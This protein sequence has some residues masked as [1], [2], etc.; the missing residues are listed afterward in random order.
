[1]RNI[2]LLAPYP[3]KEMLKDGMIQ[4][5]KI[6][7]DMLLKYDRVYL[8][9]SFSNPAYKCI[10]HT[11]N[12]KEFL[13][14]PILSIFFIIKELVKAKI[15]YAHS[16][17]LFK[18]MPYYFWFLKRKKTELILDAHGIVPEEM[19]MY[20]KQKRAKYLNYIESRV[21][22]DL[23][24]CICVSNEMILHYKRKY[25]SSNAS[26]HLFNTSK[27]LEKP[28]ADE[29]EMLAKDL[30][31][32]EN[33]CVILYSGNTQLWQN[34][35]LMLDYIV[36]LNDSGY[37]FIFL[38]GN[39]NEM[40]KIIETAGLG[41][42]NIIIRSVHHNEI[43]KYYELAHYGFILRDDIPINKV[44]NPTK[45]LEYLQF[46]LTPIVL[47]QYIGDYYSMGYEY[48][49]VRTLSS[50]TLSKKKSSKNINISYALNEENKKFEIKTL[51]S[52]I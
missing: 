32:I 28:S 8:N 33:D 5:I 31:I 43:N 50:A 38:T 14:N 15:I 23:K 37:K 25:S 34:V 45:M 13:L 26:Y 18:F 17:H 30:N 48:I 2:V 51:I 52:Q 39:V 29:V 22:R 11:E 40:Q 10:K 24:H 1:M 21:F 9:I 44:S 20:G 4:R 41:S 12:S 16:I 6:I 7:D 35:P 46:G 42:N 49:D 3:T 47:S 36:R 27:L 19:S